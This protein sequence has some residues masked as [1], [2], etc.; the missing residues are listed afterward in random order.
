MLLVLYLVRQG[1]DAR[2]TVGLMED[3][4]ALLPTPIRIPRDP[5]TLL[6]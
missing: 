5:S 4:P 1:H 2:G 6:A 3:L